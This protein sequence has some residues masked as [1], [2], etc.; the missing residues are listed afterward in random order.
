MQLSFARLAQAIIT[1]ARLNNPVL[2]DA[3]HQPGPPR[4][5]ADIFN[6]SRNYK[7]AVT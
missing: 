6:L 3:M 5:T 1:L 7:P 2:V 4:I